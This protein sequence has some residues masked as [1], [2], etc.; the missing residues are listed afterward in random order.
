MANDLIRYDLLVQEA[1]KGVVR[2]VL[3]DAAK[4]GL[5]GEHHFYI[6]FRTDFPGVRLSQRLRDK[7]PQEMT[8]VLQHQFWDLG[9]TEHTFEVGLS[10]SGVPERLLIPFDALTG[11]FDPSVSFGLKF[12]VPGEAEEEPAEAPA[13]VPHRPIRGAGSEP[14][15]LQPKKAPAPAKSATPKVPAKPAESSKPAARAEPPAETAET[16]KDK[17]DA[18]GTAQVVSLDSFRKKN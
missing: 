9:I 8:I 7:Y 12:E 4:D 13:A 3:T 17:D 1:L 14:V 18:G 15:E 11:F 5:L 6:S 16:P 10:F 2:R